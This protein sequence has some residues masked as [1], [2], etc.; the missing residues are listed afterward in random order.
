MN[1]K[2]IKELE[3]IEIPKEL[4]ERAKLGVKKAKSEQPKRKFKNRV[5]IPLAASLFLVFSVGVG[6]ASIP[7]F[8]NLLSLVSPKMALMLQP[9]E[10]SSQ[11]ED[12]KI[13]LSKD[14]E[15][16]IATSISISPLGVTLYGNGEISDS[17]NIVV[18]AKMNDG[19]VQTFDSMTSYSENGN[20][21][22]KFISSLPI[23]VS[24][25]ESINIDGTKVDF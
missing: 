22:L 3:K 18:S 24:K 14:F 5:A 21:K 8:N 17:S 10:S 7:S 2:V 1:N 12:K 9:I 20:V 4:H 15:S 23:D 11:K 19:I 13:A 6:A 16:W 25:V